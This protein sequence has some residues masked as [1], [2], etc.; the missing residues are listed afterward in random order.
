MESVSAPAGDS[1][2][3]DDNPSRYDVYAREY[4]GYRETSQD[5]LE[6]PGFRRAPRVSISM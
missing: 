6:P 3:E 1:W 4:P 2:G 5:P